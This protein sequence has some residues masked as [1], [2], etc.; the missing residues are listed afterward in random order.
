MERWEHAEAS[1][2]ALSWSDGNFDSMSFS[3]QH[4]YYWRRG[5]H[6]KSTKTEASVAVEVAERIQETWGFRFPSHR[7]KGKKPLDLAAVL[8]R[9]SNPHFAK[10]G[11]IGGGWHTDDCASWICVL[12][13]L[14]DGRARL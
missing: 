10:V 6:L 7:H 8:K 5:G 13:G 12:R 11:I 14:H 9:R 4:S 1:L 2:G 3:V